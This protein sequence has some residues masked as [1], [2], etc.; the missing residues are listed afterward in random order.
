MHRCFKCPF[1]S[2]AKGVGSSTRGRMLFLNRQGVGLK[3]VEFRSSINMVR[4][5]LSNFAVFIIRNWKPV[6]NVPRPSFDRD[7]SDDQ[8]MIWN[9]LGLGELWKATGYPLPLGLRRTMARRAFRTSLESLQ[10]TLDAWEISIGVRNHSG[11]P[12]QVP[13]LVERR[14]SPPRFSR[15]G[16]FYSSRGSPRFRPYS[17]RPVSR[18]SPRSPS[19][20]SYR[21]ESRE[22]RHQSF[23]DYRCR[24][25]RDRSPSVIPLVEDIDGTF[26]YDL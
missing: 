23:E 25:D 2:L 14:R 3:S 21:S 7:W 9:S 4:G 17:E 10:S 19:P 16:R 5:E 15:G 12:R 13:A 8:V 1:V 11:S 26:V 6:K 18:R 22:S 24:E 20:R